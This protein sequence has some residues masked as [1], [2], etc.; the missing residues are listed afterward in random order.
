[1]AVDVSTAKAAVTLEEIKEHLRLDTTEENSLLE[2]YA[3]AITQRAEHILGRA[4]ITREGQEGYGDK[5]AA[6]PAAIRHW[7]LLHV[8]Q[9]YEN[10]ETK[11]DETLSTI[12]FADALLSPFK[13]WS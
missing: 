8:A 4:L 11:M 3:L 7:I 10:R 6:V 5:P 13:T 1:M 2:L 9:A 12:P